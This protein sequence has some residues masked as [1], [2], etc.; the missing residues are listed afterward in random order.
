[1]TLLEQSSCV[2]NAAN[3]FHPNLQ[4]TLE[5]TNS[6]RNLPFL[7]LNM[8]VSQDRGVTCNWYQEPTGTGTILNYRS[9][10][11]TQ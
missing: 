10:A 1:M 11:P 5:E 2:L 7:D 4:F 9:C 3:S 6:E 8:N